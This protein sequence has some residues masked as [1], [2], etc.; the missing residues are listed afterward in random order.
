VGREK[1]P[2]RGREEF[3]QRTQRRNK[4]GTEEAKDKRAA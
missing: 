3:T 4:E 1:F 2:R